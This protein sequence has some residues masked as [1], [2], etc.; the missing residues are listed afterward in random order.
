[1]QHCIPILLYHS[2]AEKVSKAYR[3]WAV[4]P[5]LFAAHMAYLQK[6]GYTPFTVTE[7]VQTM[8]YAPASLP[9]KVVVITF[10]DGLD[11]F[12]TGALPVLRQYHFPATLYITT[13]YVEGVSNWL[14][15][16]GEGERP[17]MNWQQIAELSAHGIECGAH[18]HTHSE[19]DTLP[20]A[21]AFDEIIHSKAILENKLGQPVLSF[22]YPH[23]YH[24]RTV[25][26]MVQDAG[27]TSA[28][29]VKHAMSSIRDD[30]FALARIIVS[31]NTSVTGLA[32]LLAGKGLPI[33]PMCE[34]I[35]TKLWRLLRQWRTRQRVQ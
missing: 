10:D 30:R 31:G 18:S 35:R 28:C 21:Q 6:A 4:H 14:A 9:V 1:M 3:R 17:M 7:L 13:G 24:N 22:A 16:V 15:D 26:Q 34:Q 29:G 8:I 12:Y 33:S 20:Q 27:F 32:E 23:G 25:W 2:V 11:D 19:L 5:T